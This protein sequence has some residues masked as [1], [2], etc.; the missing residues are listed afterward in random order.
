MDKYRAWSDAHGDLERRFDRDTLL[1]LLTLYWV[2]GT[3]GSS[4]RTYYDYR[5]NPPLPPVNVPAGFTLGTED[6]TYPREMA[7]RIYTDIRHW[8]PVTV[9]GHFM[10]LEEPELLAEDL[11]AF[12]RPLRTSGRE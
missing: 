4:F 2:T 11:R 3:I 1:T 10:P 5:H 7:E 9:G 8:R 12:F 6:R